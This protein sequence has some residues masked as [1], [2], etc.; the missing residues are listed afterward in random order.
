M[1]WES[2]PG[3]LEIEHRVQIRSLY[4]RTRHRSGFTERSHTTGI[5]WNF[6][7]SAPRDGSVFARA[8]VMALTGWG[9][10]GAFGGIRAATTL[11]RCWWLQRSARLPVP[12]LRL[13][14][15]PSRVPSP[16]LAWHNTRISAPQSQP[17]GA[18]SH[19]AA[20]CD[21]GYRGA[22]PSTY[23]PSA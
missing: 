20:G 5:S 19:G 1:P 12:A 16:G 4:G 18:P 7:A 10:G 6:L 15:A 3:V 8:L 23:C 13:P 11:G 17:M 22:H 14:P 9:A 2:R 21:S